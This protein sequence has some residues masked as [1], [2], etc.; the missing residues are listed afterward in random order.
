MIEQLMQGPL[1]LMQS[2]A[3]RLNEQVRLTTDLSYGIAHIKINLN[4]CFVLTL[5]VYTFFSKDLG[6]WILS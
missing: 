5:V 4:L 2:L 6:C 3:G 1:Q